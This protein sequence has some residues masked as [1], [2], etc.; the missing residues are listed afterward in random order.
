MHISRYKNVAIAR[1][2]GREKE[3]EDEEEEEDN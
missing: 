2:E 3:G 1:Y